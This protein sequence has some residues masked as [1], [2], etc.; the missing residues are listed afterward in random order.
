MTSLI[1]WLYKCLLCINKQETH[2]IH[3]I[4]SNI[5]K[6]KTSININ[7]FSH[8]VLSDND[9]LFGCR[10][11]LDTWAD[12]SC[13]GK[14]AYVESFIEGK[15]VNATGFTSSLGT[16]KDLPIANVLYAYDMNDG[17]TI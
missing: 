9:I 8:P 7:E 12:T 16:M 15:T 14:H 5:G 17:T 2:F 13:S 4:S 3:I 11:G 6:T 1:N 10:L